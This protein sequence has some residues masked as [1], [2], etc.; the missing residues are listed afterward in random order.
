MFELTISD[1][2]VEQF[3]A[4]GFIVVDRIISDADVALLRERF[5]HLFR[6][7]WETGLT[8]D[9]VNWRAGRDPEDVTRQLCN[10][11]KADR[12]LASVVLRVDIGRACARLGRW[13]GT[14]ISQDNI[15][16]KPPGGKALGFHQDSSYEKWTTIPDWVSC[17]IALDDTTAAG[18]TV[19][20]VRGSN[21]WGESG[22]IEQFHAPDD[23]ATDLV[24]AAQRAGVSDIERVPVVVKAGGGAFHSGWTWHGSDVNRSA[25]PRRSVVA[26]CM[27]SATRFHPDYVGYIYSRYKRFGSDEMDESFFPVLWREDGY[28]SP[29]I[30]PFVERRISWGGNY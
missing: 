18:G 22:M 16:W 27:S 7:E 1:E 29:F 14:R 23:P 17:W 11:W 13:P 3:H 8:P 24:K 15:L 25:H 21:H 28:R 2:Q 30:E 6:G 10:G 5:D 19:E 12:Y 4:D 20:Y 26:H 9:E